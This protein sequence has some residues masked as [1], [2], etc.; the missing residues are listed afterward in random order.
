MGKGFKTN[1]THARRQNVGFDVVVKKLFEK[2]P[3]LTVV[4]PLWLWILR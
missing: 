4:K 1:D 2:S 3:L